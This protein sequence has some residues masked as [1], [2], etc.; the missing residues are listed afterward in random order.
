[1]GK[2]KKDSSAVSEKLSSTIVKGMQEKKANDIVL[3]D[4]RKIEDAVADYFVICDAIS[5]TQVK[6]IADHVLAKTQKLTGEKPWHTEGIENQQWVLL[7][8]V[9]VVVHIF[10]TPVRNFYQLEEL[11][12][13]AQIKHY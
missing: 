8:Y 11:W 9:N 2:R 3:M 1:M 13:D 6:A 4:L 12:S 5:Q 7:D 10:R